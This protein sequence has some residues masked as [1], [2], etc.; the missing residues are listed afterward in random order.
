MEKG[1]LLFEELEGLH[2]CV[3]CERQYT[4]EEASEEPYICRACYEEGEEE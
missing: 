4:E 2:Q 1:N 3:C